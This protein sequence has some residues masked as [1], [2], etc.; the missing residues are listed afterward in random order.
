MI[1]AANGVMC[2][3]Q[4]GI[5]LQPF[6]LHPSKGERGWEEGKGGGRGYTAWH[7]A[8]QSMRQ[9]HE[10]NVYSLK[11]MP[12]LLSWHPVLPAAWLAVVPDS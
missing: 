6:K 3:L 12:V 11:Q 1:G 10:R 9:M 8:V 7:M 2:W 5:N 4:A